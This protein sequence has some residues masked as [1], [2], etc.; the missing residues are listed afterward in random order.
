[1]LGI[2]AIIRS[3][4]NE[5][6]DFIEAKDKG[7][8]ERMPILTVFR[9]HARE[10]VAITFAQAAPNTFFYAFSVAIVSYAVTRLGISQSRMLAAVCV[11]AFAEMCAIP[12]FGSLADRVPRRMVYVWGLLIMGLMAYPFFLA[13]LSNSYGWMLV[14]YAVTFGLG[15]AACH[16]S[17]AALFAEMFPTTVRYTGL[18]LG[19]QVSGAV[20][21]GPLPVIATLLIAAQSGQLWYFYGYTICIAVLSLIAIFAGRAHSTPLTGTQVSPMSRIPPIEAIPTRG[22]KSSSI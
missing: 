20:F 22:G 8:I 16:A 1:M 13:L 3:K 5:S 9:K 2:G 19:Y 7:A 21:A 18:S 12:L 10:V 11:G 14:C 6:P 15:H 17:Q 4:V